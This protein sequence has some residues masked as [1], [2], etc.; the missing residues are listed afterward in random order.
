MWAVE[1]NSAV[2]ASAAKQGYKVMVGTYDEVS[3]RL[4]EAYFDLV[5]AND[6][7]EHMPDHDSFLKSVTSVMQ[8]GGRLMGSVPNM[9]YYPV[10]LGLVVRGRWD[11]TDMG[12]LD[13][14][15]LRWFTI[16]SLRK[17]LE[18]HGFSVEHLDGINR[19]RMQW[20]HASTA[21]HAVVRFAM[22]CFT[23]GASGDMA[24]PQIAFRARVRRE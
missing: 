13:R 19:D 14:T 10:L 12:V 23:L 22:M 11:Y 5:I 21:V 8:P 4:P 17:T 16:R 1:P 20:G 2:A 9:R 6:V 24:F 7:I 3:N 15:H 18:Q